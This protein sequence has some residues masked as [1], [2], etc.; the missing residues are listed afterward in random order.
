MPNLFINYYS[1]IEVDQKPKVIQALLGHKSAKTTIITY[2]SVDKSYFVKAT[3]VLNNQF[4]VNQKQNDNNSK[5]EI[6]EGEMDEFLEWKK[7]RERKRK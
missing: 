2:N 5:K 6:S 7:E 1:Q 4:N 3:D